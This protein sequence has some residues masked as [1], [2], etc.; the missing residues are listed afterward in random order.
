MPSNR[1]RKRLLV[2]LVLV[3]VVIVH[4][5]VPSRIGLDWPTVALLG[6]ALFLLFAPPLEFL[7]PFVKTIKIG[8]TEIELR[9]QATAL[10][11]S[12]EKLEESVPPVTASE[13]SAVPLDDRY[14]RL[15]NTNVEAH[16]LDLAVKD[17]QAALMRLAIEIEKELLILHA[18]IGL[19]NE[20]KARNFREVVNQ[21]VH[22]GALGDEMRKGLM[23]FWS[24]RNQIAHSHLSDDSILT[25][26]LDS[27][28]RLLRLIKAIPRARYTVVDPHVVLFTDRACVEQITEYN[29]VLIETTEADGSKRRQVYPAGR[30]FVVGE[31]VG[32][33]WEMSKTYGAAF[34]RSPETG[35]PMEAWGA[36]MPFVGQKLPISER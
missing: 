31:M 1:D 34:Y 36:S 11:D 8:E 13:Q 2:G 19:R 6:V 10:A 18:T 4:S 22:R 7:L 14:K 9:Q 15:V 28:I 26:A 29:G 23:E 20:Y 27:G 17:K 12:V 35:E 30:Q 25:S 16:I 3:L 24:V 33:D 5:L 32:W 21:L